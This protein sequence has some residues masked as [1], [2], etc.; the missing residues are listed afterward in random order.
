MADPVITVN[1]VGQIG[2]GACDVEHDTLMTFAGADVL[3]AGTILARDTADGGQW[4]IYAKGG[5]TNGNGVAQG[6]LAYAVTATGASDIALD[7]IVRG[8]VNETRLVIDAD[9]DASNV[10]YTVTDDLRDSNILV[11]PV[12]QLAQEDNQA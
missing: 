4:Q 2:I 7:V 5:S 3:A 6:V 12:L 1:D 9:G 10:D 11:K 8:T